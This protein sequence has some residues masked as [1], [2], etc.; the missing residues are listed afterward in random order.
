MRNQIILL[1]ALLGVLVLVMTN[2]V[3]IQNTI[4]RVLSRGIRNNNPGNIRKT[5]IDWKGEV[6]DDLKTDDEFEKFIAPLF[7]IRA[8]VRILNK[9]A[10]AGR[11]T[12][13]EIITRWAPP[14]ENDTDAY[15]RSV[16]RRTG[17]GA[18]QPIVFAERMPD[19]LDAI[20]THENGV[21]PYADQLLFEA[22]AAA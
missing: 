18:D 15:I 3:P 22:I 8:I 10:A 5:S 4:S 6:P 21:N 14:S 9:G 13:R 7:G 1:G 19:L 11:D 17:L 20:I 12:V 2:Q 16:S